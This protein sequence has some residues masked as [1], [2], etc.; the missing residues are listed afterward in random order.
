MGG[1]DGLAVRH[2]DHAVGCALGG[3]I[4]RR[5]GFRDGRV[6]GSPLAAVLASCAAGGAVGRTAAQAAR[7]R[8]LQPRPGGATLARAAAG[9]RGLARRL[10]PGGG[11]ASDGVLCP[12]LRAGLPILPAPARGARGSRRGQRQAYGEQVRLGGRGPGVGWRVGR[13]SFSP[14]GRRLR[15]P[16]LPILRGGDVAHPE[17][18]AGPARGGHRQRDGQRGDSGNHRRRASGGL[19]RHPRKP[20]PSWPSRARPPPTT[21]SGMRWRPSC[22]C[23]R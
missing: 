12:V 20:V 10:A 19:S 7:A 11:C 21:C 17:V 2:P 13:G 6:E 3:G 8:P 14:R 18:R 23:G 22:C 9:G 1:R 16:L 15:R 5:V 4:A